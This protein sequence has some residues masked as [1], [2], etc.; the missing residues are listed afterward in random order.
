MAI[1]ARL[2]KIEKT[3]K[4]G[5]GFA[6]KNVN[7]LISFFQTGDMERIPDG[8]SIHEL[9]AAARSIRPDDVEKLSGLVM[10]REALG[11]DCPGDVLNYIARREHGEKILRHFISMAEPVMDGAADR[12]PKKPGLGDRLLE[13][14]GLAEIMVFRIVYAEKRS[15]EVRP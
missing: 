9:K 3:M 14:L 11:A 15:E 1:K 2:E 6:Y 8:V 13:R 4:Q 12:Q 10:L 7:D 5:G